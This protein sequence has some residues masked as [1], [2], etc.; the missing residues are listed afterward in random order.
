MFRVLA[1]RIQPEPTI[2]HSLSCNTVVTGRK[3]MHTLTHTTSVIWASAGVRE[4]WETVHLSFNFSS[5]IQLHIASQMCD[6]LKLT[7]FEAQV[8]FRL[9]LCRT[10]L[11]VQWWFGAKQNYWYNLKWFP[12]FTSWWRGWH[13]GN[14]IRN[15]FTWFI[16]ELLEAFSFKMSSEENL[17]WSLR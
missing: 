9:S 1:P 2:S 5:Q 4:S 17:K 6:L 10:F 11:Q 12:Y 3:E 13:L 15:E 7:Y 16:L 14:E 8:Y